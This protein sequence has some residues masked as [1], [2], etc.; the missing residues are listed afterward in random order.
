LRL[1][2]P[3]RDNWEKAIRRVDGVLKNDPKNV[4]ALSAKADL[5]RQ[6]R[7]LDE[8]SKAADAALAADR[9]SPAAKLARGRVLVA[10]GRVARAEQSFKEWLQLS[11]QAV[12]P[13]VELARRP[14]GQG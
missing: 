9:T 8:A 1:L 7:K 12:A 2:T 13:Q 3:S 6:Q 11:P 4:M 14:H 5:L 10:Q